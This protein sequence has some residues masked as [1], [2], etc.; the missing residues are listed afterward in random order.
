MDSGVEEGG[1]V[2]GGVVE[3]GI[4]DGCLYLGEGGHGRSYDSWT[5]CD[6]DRKDNAVLSVHHLRGDCV[7]PPHAG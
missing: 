4:V 1:V 7:Q 6:R 3:G 5:W 2:E